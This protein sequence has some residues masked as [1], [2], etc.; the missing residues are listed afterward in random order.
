MNPAIFIV[1]GKSA[2]TTLTSLIDYLNSLHRPTVMANL[3]ECQDGTPMIIEADDSLAEDND[4]PED[5]ESRQEQNE[6]VK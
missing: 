1:K 4:L 6:E 5:Q 2:L 3:S